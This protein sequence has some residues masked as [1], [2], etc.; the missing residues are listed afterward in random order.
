MAPPIER[1]RFRRIAASACGHFPRARL[2]PG[3]E[4]CLID[5]SRGGARIEATSRLLPGTPEDLQL[6]VA[7]W[8]WTGRA[9]I[10]RCRVSALVPE[11]GVRYQA[12]LQFD[13]PIDAGAQMALESVLAGAS[14]CGYQVPA[15]EG[16]APAHMGSDYPL[17]HLPRE[18][19]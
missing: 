12:A 10:L 6:I 11:D 15:I 2:R 19:K 7:T 9:R 1:R 14:E 5:L 17:T 16:S 8:R 18:V 4:A 3:R 13:P